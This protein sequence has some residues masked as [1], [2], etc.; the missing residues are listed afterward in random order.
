MV[1]LDEMVVGEASGRYELLRL[2]NKQD[3]GLGTE[4]KSGGDR[5]MDVVAMAHLLQLLS[6][7]F[8]A[9]AKVAPV[10]DASGCD[11]VD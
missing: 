7:V 2:R 3:F 8:A 10:D 4:R 1:L 9:V 11:Q 6:L 5:D